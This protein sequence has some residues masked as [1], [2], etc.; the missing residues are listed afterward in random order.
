MI[1]HSAPDIAS[2][3]L[4][5]RSTTIDTP[6]IVIYT[7][8]WTA[9]IR[10]YSMIVPRLCDIIS[11][12]VL[13]T[14]A[15]SVYAYQSPATSGPLLTS[16]LPVDFN[17]PIGITNLIISSERDGEYVFIVR[18]DDHDVYTARWS[19]SSVW[20]SSVTITSD[21]DL[22]PTF[23]GGLFTNY[24]IR[25]SYG[26]NSVALNITFLTATTVTPQYYQNQVYLP[27]QSSTYL[28]GTW[29]QSI[30]LA[31]STAGDIITSIRINSTRD[32]NYQL[33][34]I[35]SAPD[36]HSIT[37]FAS[38]LNASPDDSLRALDSSASYAFQSSLEPRQIFVYNVTYGWSDLLFVAEYETSNSL[39]FSFN[40]GVSSLAPA[41]SIMTSL[42]SLSIGI[43]TLFI[44]SKL[45]GPY[46]LIIDRAEADVRSLSL[47]LFD[48][49]LASVSTSLTAGSTWG[50]YRRHSYVAHLDR[51][52]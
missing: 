24:S 31:D 25:V 22:L 34:L 48:D 26:I 42:L 44:E 7:P 40:G 46:T 10:T 1:T 11:L 18:R 30:I 12:W 15:N 51:S 28:S 3:S 52:L 6:F 16:G 41:T 47:S 17:L 20:S 19:S 36:I 32:G 23:I 43:N 21:S 49:T 14:T 45:D 8:A 37:L 4:S 50:V 33:Q 27:I 35:R 39:T 38:R 5:G 13:M 9:S 2:I 29:S